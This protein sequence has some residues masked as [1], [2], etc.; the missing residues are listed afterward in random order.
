MVIDGEKSRATC[1]RNVP[2]EVVL[3]RR[4][5]LKVASAP[6]DQAAQKDAQ[7]SSQHTNPTAQTST[8]TTTNSE[9]FKRLAT[10]SLLKK[11][12]IVWGLFMCCWLPATVLHSA[13]FDG[14]LDRRVMHVAFVVAQCNSAVNALTYGALSPNIRAAYRRTLCCQPA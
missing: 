3:Y 13:D 11:L 5:R 14:H 12:A 1:W 4:A 2:V 7:E 8:N 6:A 9:A 10:V